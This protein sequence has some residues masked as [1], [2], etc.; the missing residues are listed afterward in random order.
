[1]LDNLSDNNS[2]QLNNRYLLL[3]QLQKNRGRYTHLAKDLQTEQLVVIKVLLFNQ[4]FRWEDLKLFVREAETL[5]SLSHPG[6]PNYIDYFE[7]D[8]SNLQGF[9]LVQT[10]ILAESLQAHIENGRN[11]NERDIKQLGESLLAILDYLHS[12]QPTVIHRDLKP[13]NILLANRTG[14]SVGNVYV[15][16][17][18]SVQTTIQSNSTRTVV[19]TYGYMPPEQ[20]GG[21][22]CPASDIYSLG[23]TLIYLLT[24][25]HPAELLDDDLSFP[26]SNINNI[27]SELKLWLKLMTQASL[28]RRFNSAAL[29]LKYL[30]NLSDLNLKYSQDLQVA[31]KPKFSKIKL[32]ITPEEL[33]I[34]FPR[35]N[36]FK[37]IF[38]I[39]KFIFEVS[40]P[41]IMVYGF[42][43]FFIFV[44][45]F[46]RN[47][48]IF[49]LD[50][51]KFIPQ[52]LFI[53]CG[54]SISSLI[55]YLLSHTIL[56]KVYL[57]IDKTNVVIDK[58]IF[59]HTSLSLSKPI[60]IIPR[61]YIWKLVSTAQQYKL[62]KLNQ[63]YKNTDKPPNLVIWEGTINHYDLNSY[64]DLPLSLDERNWI[65]QEISN[66]LD[67]PITEE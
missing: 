28:N 57:K 1:M 23:A 3:K 52:Y 31:I 54:I 37:S 14:N 42:I 16:D 33:Y 20:F 4:E 12:R 39:F 59:S 27:S 44:S 47:K 43:F 15:V 26:I 38:T 64:L 46:S 66:F 30:E 29:A 35:K 65:A 63:S 24:K 45:L 53:A 67:I 6:I 49:I 50:L 10:Y 48:L 17:F 32:I 36:I 2:I 51:I 40:F 21:R 11:F 7:L 41:F 25:K 9:A 61:A 22:V 55:L 62:T 13:S 19:G 58:Q 8:I 60:L 56:A 34:F 5:K 18:G